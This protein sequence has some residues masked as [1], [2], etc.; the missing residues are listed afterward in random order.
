MNLARALSLC[1]LILS[2][3]T[4]AHAASNMAIGELGVRYHAGQAGKSF[5]GATG[6]FAYFQSNIGKGVFRP[7]VGASLEF[8]T[9]N[10]SV[11]SGTPSGNAYAGGI[12]PGFDFFFF[13]TEKIQP[14]V[15]MHGILSWVYA[16][17]SPLAVKSDETSLGL[18]F[19]FQVGGGADIRVGKGERA[20][21][22]HTNYQNYAGKVAGTAG[23]QFSAFG[24]SVGLVF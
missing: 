6:I 11:G 16:S 22:I 24:L 17:L 7:N 5:T 3:A 19:G 15:E 9:G 23:F 18:A 12:Y 1:S 14:F 8:I 10:A 13:K 21:R 20:I 2:L 4:S